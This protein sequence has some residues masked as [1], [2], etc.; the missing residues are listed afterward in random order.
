MLVNPTIPSTPAGRLIFILESLHRALGR[1]ADAQRLTGRGSIIGPI[2]ML[3]WQRVRRIGLRFAARAAREA[4]TPPV[5]PR[6]GAPRPDRQRQY[7][8]DPLPR[9]KAWLLTL[10]P[11]TA[12]ISGQLRHFLADPEVAALLASAPR[13]QSILNPLC[14]MLG[15]QAAGIRPTQALPPSLSPSPSQPPDAAPAR[16]PIPCHAPKQAKPAAFPPVVFLPWSTP[17]SLDA[18]PFA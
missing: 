1:H 13:L 8:P 18:A 10:I 2:L 4:I 6:P 7:Q 14:H 12:P 9:R 5:P 16:C 3:I 17:P 15:I 11:E